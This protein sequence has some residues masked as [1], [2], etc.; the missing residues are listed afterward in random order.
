[1]NEWYPKQIT[2]THGGET[3]RLEWEMPWSSCLVI[4]IFCKRRQMITSSTTVSCR[5]T[6][7]TKSVQYASVFAREEAMMRQTKHR[8]A[9]SRGSFSSPTFYP[10]GSGSRPVWLSPRAF[11]YTAWHDKSGKASNLLHIFGPRSES[12]IRNCDFF[13]ETWENLVTGRSDPVLNILPRHP[14]RLSVVSNTATLTISHKL[15]L[16]R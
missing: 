10:V 11:K 2:V 3:M 12:S 8:S 14:K 4:E 5:D 15:V 6:L 16:N 9:V 13:T 1:M 7:V